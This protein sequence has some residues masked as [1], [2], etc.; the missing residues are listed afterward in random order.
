MPVKT[1]YRI[2]GELAALG[3]VKLSVNATV[4]AAPQDERFAKSF[5]KFAVI[6]SHK[7]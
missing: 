6:N 2:V 1:C 5:L 7:L 4:S 3:F